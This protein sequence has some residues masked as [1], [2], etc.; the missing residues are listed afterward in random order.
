MVLK[1][2]NGLN[3]LEKEKETNKVGEDIAIELF[4]KYNHLEE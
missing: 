1:S 2:A 3:D 4:S